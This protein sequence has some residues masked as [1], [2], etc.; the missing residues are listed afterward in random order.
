[1]GRILS[2]VRHSCKHGVVR[3]TIH[4]VGNHISVIYELDILCIGILI[5][6][7]RHEILY[8]TP[9]MARFHHHDD[10]H[11]QVGLGNGK[12]IDNIVRF[13]T[14]AAKEHTLICEQLAN[15]TQHEKYFVTIK[16]DEILSTQNKTWW[17]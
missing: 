7:V 3:K 10:V 1:M 15:V 4:Q 6:T 5:H 11:L 12:N 9:R 16:G 13:H 14:I 17:N 8:S 2:N